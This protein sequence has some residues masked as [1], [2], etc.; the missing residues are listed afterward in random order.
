MTVS[1]AFELVARGLRVLG[2]Q[3]YHDAWYFGFLSRI[4][5]GQTLNAHAFFA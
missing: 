5:A 3:R 1:E 2:L 4:V